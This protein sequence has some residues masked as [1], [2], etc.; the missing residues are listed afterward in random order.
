MDEEEELLDDLSLLAFK[1][2]LLCASIDQ[3]KNFYKDENTFL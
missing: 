2:Q 1:N 3:L